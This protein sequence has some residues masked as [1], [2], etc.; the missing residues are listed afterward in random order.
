MDERLTVKQ[1]PWL[2]ALIPIVLAIVV[3]ASARQIFTRPSLAT[4]TRRANGE[5]R[6]GNYDVATQILTDVAARDPGNGAAWFRLGYAHHTAKAYSQAIEAYQKAYTL[7][8]IPE[9]TAYNLACAY[10]LR[11]EAGRAVQWLETALRQGFR[12]TRLLETDPDLD[13]VRDDPGFKALMARYEKVS[14]KAGF[15]VL[16]P[17]LGTW[18]ALDEKRAVVG[19][20]E[21]RSMLKGQAVQQI[22]TVGGRE[23][24]VSMY[25]FNAQAKLWKQV[26]ASG[27]GSFVERIAKAQL[28]GLRFEGWAY[29][30][31][32]SNSMDRLVFTEFEGGYRLGHEVSSDNG[33][34][35]KKDKELLLKKNAGAGPR[36]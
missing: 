28:D 19:T 12:D 7:E 6:R 3:I 33:R 9:T 14:P 29:S 11:G 31:S 27:D 24:Q 20:V 13:P 10:A 35:W 25:Y 32:G 4:L 21:F 5:L 2:L 8:W 16:R 26:E 30:A 17:L 36:S 18:T 34:T 15:A 23:S 22:T 1:R